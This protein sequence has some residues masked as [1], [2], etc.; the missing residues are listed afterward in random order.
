MNNGVWSRRKASDKYFIVKK[1]KAHCFDV[2][3]NTCFPKA[4]T[5]IATD[6]LQ[7]KGLSNLGE[8][9]CCLHKRQTKFPVGL[10]IVYDQRQFEGPNYLH[11]SMPGV[12][13]KER[14]RFWRNTL[15]RASSLQFLLTNNTH[16]E[17]AEDIT[18]QFQKT[19]SSLKECMQAVS[20]VA[21]QLKIESSPL[22]KRKAV[23]APHYKESQI[24]S[25]Y[26]KRPLEVQSH[27][28][29]STS[30]LSPLYALAD[31][32]AMKSRIH[33]LDVPLED[34]PFLKIPNS[35]LCLD[36]T[37][38][39]SNPSSLVNKILKK[40]SE[41]KTRQTAVRYT[42]QVIIKGLNDTMGAVQGIIKSSQLESDQR[43]LVANNLMNSLYLKLP[44]LSL[45]QQTKFEFTKD[46]I[47]ETTSNKV[48]LE[49]EKV[50]IADEIWEGHFITFKTER[51]SELFPLFKWFKEE[52]SR[53]LVS[54]QVADERCKLEHDV[55]KLKNSPNF[56]NP[57][58]FEKVYDVLTEENFNLHKRFLQSQI[59]DETNNFGFQLRI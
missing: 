30:L 58:E 9:D 3:L 45:T 34:S 8:Q 2:S 6:N 1:G 46:Q 27:L 53:G 50:V 39:V 40:K 49:T 7:E 14:T 11:S 31:S 42:A 41:L 4:S 29:P 36:R 33:S 32:R 52:E 17:W 22:N 25:K 20:K 5:I 48:K 13:Y 38:G 26:F 10:S 43:R 59:L 57:F 35:P 54:F 55:I 21:S 37:H 12:F 23:V 47:T 16:W 44:E 28:L 56:I 18:N 51:D 24:S 19:A 15:N